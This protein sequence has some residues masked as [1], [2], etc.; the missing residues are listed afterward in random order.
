MGKSIPIQPDKLLIDR[1]E[2]ATN[3]AQ[4]GPIDLLGTDTRHPAR[5]GLG[6]DLQAAR[7]RRLVGL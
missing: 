1:F 6:Q 7:H 3:N 2:G 4:K 5:I